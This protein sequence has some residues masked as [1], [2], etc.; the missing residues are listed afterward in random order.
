[1]VLH[2]T[3]ALILTPFEASLFPTDWDFVIQEDFPIH[4]LYCQETK[5]I[6]FHS[7]N[8]KTDCDKE[9]SKI[10]ILLEK[11]GICA[12]YQNKVLVLKDGENEYSVKDVMHHL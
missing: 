1:M 8:Q 9:V 4:V 2:F 7:D 10:K 11:I 3:Y 12:I 6:L 5:Q